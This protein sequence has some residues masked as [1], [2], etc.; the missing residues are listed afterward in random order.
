MKKQNLILLVSLFCFFPVG[1]AFAEPSAVSPGAQ[2]PCKTLR[3]A[4]GAAGYVKGGFKQ[5]KGLFRNCMKPLLSGSSVPGVSVS[6][7]D[8]QACKARKAHRDS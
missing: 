5:G 8:V 7:E 3:A 4:C 1:Q 2:H 6:A